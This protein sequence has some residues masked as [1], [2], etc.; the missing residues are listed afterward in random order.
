MC[1]FV[2]QKKLLQF[3]QTKDYKI[4]TILE[5]IKLH[6]SP[7]YLSDI[8]EVMNHCN[9]YLQGSGSKSNVDDFGI[10]LTGVGKVRLASH[11]R[12]F[13]PHDVALQLFATNT[14]DLFCFAVVLTPLISSSCVVEDLFFAV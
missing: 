7:F 11:T 3:F 10:K 8:L 9:C 6:S 13:D 2:L 12:L 4:H 1:L 5:G 14:E